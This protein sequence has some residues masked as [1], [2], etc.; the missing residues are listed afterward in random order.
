MEARRKG[1]SVT[2]YEEDDDEMLDSVVMRS[3]SKSKTGLGARLSKFFTGG[4]SAPV[5]AKREHHEFG[6]VGHI[7]AALSMFLFFEQ[8]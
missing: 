4:K 6:K 8:L 5:P 3:A 1:R 2:R 7:L